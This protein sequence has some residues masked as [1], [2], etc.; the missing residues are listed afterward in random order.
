[1]YPPQTVS[2]T[3]PVCGRQFPAQV[4]TIIDVGQDP[5]AKSKLLRGQINVATCP[6]CGNA[7]M[8]S[9]PIVYHDPDK[10]LFLCFL[11]SEL[12]S[13]EQHRFVGD[14]TNRLM[15]YLPSCSPRPSSPCRG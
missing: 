7:G 5:E 4:Q 8:L 9:A 12:N 3:C 2:V 6:Q 1:M 11:P 10:E 14:M 13:D 15:S